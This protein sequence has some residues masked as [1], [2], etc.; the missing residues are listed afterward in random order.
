MRRLP[1]PAAGPAG[2]HRAR[3]AH[4]P[5]GGQ[6]GHGKAVLLALLV[7]LLAAGGLAGTVRAA[8]AEAAEANPAFFPVEQ[9]RPGLTGYGLTVV[10]GTRIERFDVEVLGLVQGIGPAGDLVLVRVGGAALRPF[11]GIAAGMSGS[12]VYV[13]GRLL[14]AIGF[15]FEFTDHSVGLVTP[16]GDMLRVLELVSDPEGQA[17]AEPAASTLGQGVARPTFRRVAWAA[18]RRAAERIKAQAPPGTAVMVPVAT[19]L[20]LGGL[21]GRTRQ[22][23]E[24][25]LSGLHLLSVPVAGSL[26]GLSGEIGPPPALEPGSA[27]AVSL[28]RGDVE[29]TA[30]GTVTYVEGDRYVALGHPFLQRGSV[31]FFAAPAY[32]YRTVPRLTVP[33]KIG[34]AFAPMGVL[35]EDRRAGVAGRMGV[36]ARPVRVEV[37][38]Q[39]LSSGRRSTLRAEVVRDESLTVPLVA[40]TVLEALDRGLDRIGPGTARVIYRIRGNRLGGGGAYSRDNV[41]YSRL[42]ISARLMGDLLDTLQALA[43]NRF[44][45]IDLT[46]IQVTVQVEQ[47]RRTS[48]I[49]RARPLQDRVQPGGTVGIEVELHPYRGAPETRVLT[50]QIPENVAPGLVTVTVRGG[51]EQPV[52]L[53]TDL[54]GLFSG[55]GPDGAP[56]EEAEP[57]EGPELQP[58]T[59]LEKLL[60]ALDDREK[61]HQLVAEFY[62][63]VA[64]RPRSSLAAASGETSPSARVPGRTTSPSSGK[65]QSRTEG[66]R[67]GDSVRAV[68]TTPWVIEGS[69]EVELTIE[70]PG[71]AQG[72]SALR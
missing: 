25:W 9:V 19:P 61:N 67:P 45:D 59:S 37:T 16:I 50:L 12:P 55:E 24:R 27:L 52:A 2:F 38:V 29:L 7:C 18:D 44:R 30:I 71:A 53:V 13:D 31:E 35:Q 34:A 70:E 33:F 6:G 56:D 10:E 69:A 5:A 49:V 32:I 21:G 36:Q 62:P 20:M 22:L 47:A 54:E 40:L 64:D 63:G 41:Y 72:P 23:A 15:S 66:L 57:I 51:S 4:R 65:S 3:P 28:A 11:G 58:A 60:E 42:D 8:A 14:G 1:P 68:L 17:P 43:Y 48:S 39:D 26:S 46:D